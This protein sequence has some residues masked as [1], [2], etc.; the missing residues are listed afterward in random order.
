MT[1]FGAELDWEAAKKKAHALFSVLE[2]V[3]GS[4]NFLAGESITLADVA[5]YTYIAHAPEGGVS[6][7]NYPAIS[8]WLKRIEGVPGF[9]P[10]A[11]SPVVA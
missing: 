1:V 9:V 10:M 2:D 3:L 6:L 5:G 7:D 4:R 11:S 8:A